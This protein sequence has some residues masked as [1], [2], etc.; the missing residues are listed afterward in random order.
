MV[1]TVVVHLTAKNE[2]V[3]KVKA[4]L[5]QASRVYVKDQGTI[6][7]YVH[8]DATD[9]TKFTIVERYEQGSYAQAHVNHPYFKE[10]CS[11]VNPLLAKPWEI[12]QLV[13]LD[14]SNE[15]EVPPQTW[16]DETKN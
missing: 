10:F 13:E 5:I 11:Y 4:K 7:W 2:H 6:N 15:V 8:Q 9:P 12:H 16:S 1:V 3:D 14:T